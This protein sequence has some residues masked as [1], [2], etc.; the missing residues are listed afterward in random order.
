MTV[1][2]NRC[3]QEATHHYESKGGEF[4]DFCD[5]CEWSFRSWLDQTDSEEESDR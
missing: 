2:C 1:E 5:S 4:V 3:G